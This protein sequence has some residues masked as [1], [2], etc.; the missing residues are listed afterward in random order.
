MAARWRR[1]SWDARGARARRTW[2]TW[3]SPSVASPAWRGPCAP[4]RNCRRSRRG[5]PRG[6]RRV[7]C[8]PSPPASASSAIRQPG[9]CVALPEPRIPGL[10]AAERSAVP[11]PRLPP[12]WPYGPW[13]PCLWPCRSWPC[14]RCSLGFCSC[15]CACDDLPTCR[16][17][18]TPSVS[19]IWPFRGRGEAG[20][21][22][23]LNSGLVPA[24]EFGIRGIRVMLCIQLYTMFVC[25]S[26]CRP[27]M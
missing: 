4:P 6:P 17:D 13:R 27:T 14:R 12:C 24:W 11:P 3:S 9:S 22:A 18:N 23:R 21:N 2:R 5:W 16:R 19:A 20:E 15:S 10:A 26:C 1:C 25:R 8:A 7:P